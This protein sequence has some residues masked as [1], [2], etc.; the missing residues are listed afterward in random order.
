MAKKYFL[1]AAELG[2]QDAI[3]ALGPKYRTSRR[4]SLARG[5]Q[6]DSGYGLPSFQ[7]ALE[8]VDQFHAVKHNGERPNVQLQ[9]VAS[10]G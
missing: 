2:L 9:L 3:V 8:N 4:E 10:R 6:H 5:Q 1:A 7:F